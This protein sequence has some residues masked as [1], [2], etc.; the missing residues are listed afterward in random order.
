MHGQ[1]DSIGQAF[2]GPV[3]GVI[4]Q[5]IAIGTALTVSALALLPSLVLYR[6]A[7][8]LDESPDQPDG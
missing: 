1:A 3:V 5:R 4:A 2:G 7:A 6:R 8:G